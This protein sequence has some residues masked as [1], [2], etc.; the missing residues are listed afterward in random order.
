[1][2]HI[3]SISGYICIL[4]LMVLLLPVSSEELSTSS[5]TVKDIAI[6]T[7]V[8]NRTPEGTGTAFPSNVNKLFCFTKIEG[9]KQPTNIRH[10]WYYRD[11]IMAEVT[12]PIASSNY[13][14]FSSK[15]ILPEWKGE[16]KVDILSSEGA[17]LASITFNIQD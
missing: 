8:V 14:T 1:M 11:K 17:S 9:A 15:S 13:K 10:I 16:W 3:I 7:S 4:L 5:L 6:A 12:L 2:K